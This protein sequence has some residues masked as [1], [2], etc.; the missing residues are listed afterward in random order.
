M[1]GL[2]WSRLATCAIALEPIDVVHIDAHADFL[3]ALDGARFTGASQ[4]RRL[5]ELPSVRSATALGL[6]DVARVEAE[7]MRAM[8]V[9]WATTLDLIERGPAVVGELVRAA[10]AVRV[11][12]PRRPRPVPRSRDD[13]ARAGRAELPRAA[14]VLAEVARRAPV[15]ASDI[16][17]LNPPYDASGSRPDS[18]AGSSRT[19]S[20]RSST[21]GS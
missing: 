2:G 17:E 9:R 4:L 12:R 7:D 16:A 8:G 6:R 21:G 10:L 1:R 5:A 18:R 20:A 15:R 13:A 3:D 11:R 19:S 14:M